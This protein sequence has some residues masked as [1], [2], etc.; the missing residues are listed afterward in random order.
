MSKEYPLTVEPMMFDR[1][2]VVRAIWWLVDEWNLYKSC[3][4]NDRI[5][6]PDIRDELEYAAYYLNNDGAIREQLL[7][8]YGLAP[9]FTFEDN[10]IGMT[11]EKR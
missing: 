9:K 2:R 11:I 10:K 8:Q 5:P 4:P 6:L 1:D 3:F 7:K